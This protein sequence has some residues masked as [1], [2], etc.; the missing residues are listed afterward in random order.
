L[1]VESLDRLTRNKIL[2]AL[3]LLTG[4]LDA[5]IRIVTLADKRE[6]TAESV[7]AN[8]TELIISITVLMRAHE[9]SAM[10]AQRVGKAWAEKRANASKAIL[11]KRIPAWLTVEQGKLVVVPA[12]AAIVKRIFA[13]AIE[14]HGMNYI[15][16][17]LNAEGLPS[18]GRV[19]Y[20]QRSYIAKL[21]H[22]RAVL[23]ELQPHTK[24][25]GEK[26]SPVGKPVA[27]YYPA[28]I[29]EKDFYAVQ[30]I[31]ANRRGSGGPTTG[32]VNLFSGL[33]YS[34]DGSS[35]QSQDKGNGKRYVSSAAIN[36]Q[37]GNA[38]YIGL[39]ANMLEAAF[40]H[41]LRH[42]NKLTIQ[43][44]ADTT[45]ATELESLGGRLNELNDKITVIQNAIAATGS[46]PTSLLPVLVKLDNE[47]QALEKSIDKLKGE[48]ATAT[49]SHDAQSEA[50]VLVGEAMVED[51]ST[52]TR[53]KLKSL[54]A[55][56]VER[57]DIEVGKQ[58]HHL[59]AESVIT[60]KSGAKHELS[61][62]YN[63]RD[64]VR[65]LLHFNGD[66][67]LVDVS[68]RGIDPK[69]LKSLNLR[70]KEAGKF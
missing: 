44:T 32:W 8:P 26:R 52:A 43:P 50:F 9:E 58:G 59:C 34:T 30:N 2:S 27:N 20:W 48:L 57:I 18:I 47:K 16:R 25:R 22:S 66:E 33:L 41:W 24:R 40:L 68:E 21:L 39:N 37:S 70:L 54:I 55:R 3:S 53:L 23:G 67:V 49:T 63:R 14:G 10:K 38:G 46:N 12:R 28:I 7:N 51:L 29:K 31:M 56:L 36:G 64:C 62:T 42:N 65:M 19:G 6:Y 4:I 1:L 69:A 11:T 35:M 15:V 45:K 60:L 5:G 17:S 61:V 13:L